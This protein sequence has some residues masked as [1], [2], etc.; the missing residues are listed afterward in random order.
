MEFEEGRMYVDLTLS[1]ERR[2]TV[3]NRP[4]CV[5]STNFETSLYT[6]LTYTNLWIQQYKKKKKHAVN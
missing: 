1:C 4:F 3:S 2:E 5:L 6:L